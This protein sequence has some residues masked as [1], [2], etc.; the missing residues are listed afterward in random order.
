MRVH[1]AI[2]CTAHAA[3]AG[4]V[5]LAAA[6][7]LLACGGSDLEDEFD[8]MPTSSPSP[9]SALTPTLAPTTAPVL[10]ATPPLAAGAASPGPAPAAPA[11]PTTPPA[12]G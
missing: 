4:F 9:R 5:A 12:A 10:S 8:G 11:S 7:L 3:S 2:R 1:P 6:A